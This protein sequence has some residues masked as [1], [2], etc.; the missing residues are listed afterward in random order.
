MHEAEALKQMV[1]EMIR[2]EQQIDD[3]MVNGIA[4][5]IGD[6]IMAIGQA[7][8]SGGN[9]GQAFGSALLGTLSGVLSQFGDM[10]IAASLAGLTFSKAFKSLFDPKN[11]ALALA[12]GVAL[13]VTAG[14]LSGFARNPSSGGGGQSAS[15]TPLGSSFG[16]IRGATQFPTSTSGMAIT[17]ALSNNATLE[18]KVS[19]NDLVIL[20]NRATN[21]RNEYF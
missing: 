19:G 12:A 17:N 20:M 3:I 7:F 21:N 18:T 15:S 6:S 2:I 1:L 11:W 13:K 14:A 16:G 9:I 8:A 5:T 4:R 10:L